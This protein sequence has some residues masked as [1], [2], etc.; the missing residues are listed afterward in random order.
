MTAPTQRSSDRSTGAGERNTPATRSPCEFRLS[1]PEGAP[2]GTIAA[3]T[4]RP[5]LGSAAPTI[6]LRRSL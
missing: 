3:P 1:D 2:L 6:Y 4:G 5:V